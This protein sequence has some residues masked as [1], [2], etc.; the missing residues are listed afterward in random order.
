M[1]C[2][3]VNSNYQ[4]GPSLSF[5]KT[6]SGFREKK[7][8]L[9]GAT[10]SRA[11]GCVYCWQYLHGRISI[12]GSWV[13]WKRL[14]ERQP[15]FC[16]WLFVYQLECRLNKCVWVPSCRWHRTELSGDTPTGGSQPKS[17]STHCCSINT[18]KQRKWALSETQT[19]NTQ[20][21][22]WYFVPIQ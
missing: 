20:T 14:P 13:I 4:S 12:M 16:V 17:L 19:S 2:M 10:G 9:F 7:A 11:S 15:F 6:L 22:Y 3:S 18:I 1:L 8:C 21:T 5:N